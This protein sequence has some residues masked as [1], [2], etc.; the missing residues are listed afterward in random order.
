VWCGYEDVIQTARLLLGEKALPVAKFTG[1][2]RLITPQNVGTVLKY[3]GFGTLF[4]N[5][6]RKMLGLK[7]L[8]K[9]TALKAASLTGALT[10]KG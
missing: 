9:A 4:V 2:R 8:S 3:G 6:F 1:P 7:P 10:P 5:Q